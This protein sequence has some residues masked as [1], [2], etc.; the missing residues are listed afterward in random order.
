MSAGTPHD[1]DGRDWHA[2]ETDPV[3]ALLAKARVPEPDAWF[4]VRTLARC[5][6][7]GAAAESRGLVWNRAWRWVLGT[8]L[9]ACLALLLITRV[10]TDSS[11]PTNQQSVQEAFSILAS[12]DTDSDS[13]SSTPSSPWQDS[14]L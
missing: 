5:R 7:A 1:N 4:T 8:G 12:L 2:E 10:P 3:W 6:Y 13:T 9:G 11:A 14:S